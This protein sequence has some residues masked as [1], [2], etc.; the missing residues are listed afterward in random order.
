ML[1]NALMLTVC[2]MDAGC[3]VS[4]NPIIGSE[5][6]QEDGDSMYYFDSASFVEYPE[7]G[8]L[9]A[10]KS[11]PVFLDPNYALFHNRS[12]GSGDGGG[13]WTGDGMTDSWASEA[14]CI[15]YPEAHKRSV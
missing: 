10:I 2:V 15:P 3:K 13:I 5:Y 8:P 6:F 12:K 7:V 14:S 9:S 1:I 4:V 11:A